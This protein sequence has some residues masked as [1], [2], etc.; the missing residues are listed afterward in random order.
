MAYGDLQV[1]PIMLIFRSDASFN[2]IKGVR[3]FKW[4]LHRR[5]PGVKIDKNTFPLGAQIR[6]APGILFHEV[7]L[8]PHGNISYSQSDVPVHLFVSTDVRA[9]SRNSIVTDSPIC[10]H[11]SLFYACFCIKLFFGPT[12]CSRTVDT[13]VALNP[14]ATTA[15]YNHPPENDTHGG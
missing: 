12:D 10:V 2:G 3:S 11:V 4:L 6:F 7:S 5:R 15:D 14:F 1:F 13:A 9:R 8:S